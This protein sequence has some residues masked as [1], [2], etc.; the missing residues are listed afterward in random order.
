MAEYHPS[1]KSLSELSDALSSPYLFPGEP[2]PGVIDAGD[3]GDVRDLL[4]PALSHPVPSST[5]SSSSMLI[6]LPDAPFP[7]QARHLGA[8]GTAPSIMKTS[9]SE[10]SPSSSSSRTTTVQ[11]AGFGAGHLRAD[12]RVDPWWGLKLLNRPHDMGRPATRRSP[13]Q[14]GG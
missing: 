7:F 1:D 13:R 4:G 14:A 9:A 2:R 8:G 10:S 6:T 5:S 3:P 11:G 12:D